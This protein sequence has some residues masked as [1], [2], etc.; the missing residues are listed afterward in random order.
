MPSLSSSTRKRGLAVNAEAGASRSP[1]D[2]APQC[3]HVSVSHAC[4][5]GSHTAHA[6]SPAKQDQE[7][8]LLPPRELARPPLRR[9][10]ARESEGCPPNGEPRREHSHHVVCTPHTSYPP[11]NCI[12]DTASDGSTG[13]AQVSAAR[14]LGIGINMIHNVTAHD[15]S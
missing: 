12:V 3:L 11:F 7:H 13:C 14:C 8:A 2:C 6:T 9:V 5:T 15:Y 10:S 4:L 1:A